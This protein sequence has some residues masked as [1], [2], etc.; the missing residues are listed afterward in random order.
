MLFSLRSTAPAVE[1]METAFR[2]TLERDADAPIDLLVEYLDLPDTAPTEYVERLT[3]L[4]K[5]KYS[6]TRIDVVVPDGL[7]ALRFV[8]E[9]RGVLFPAVPVV[10]MNVT[11]EE[12]QRVQPAPDVTGV[13][14]MPGGRRTMAVALDLLPDTQLVAIVGGATASDHRNA[15]IGR[16][17]VRERPTGITVLSLVELPL[18]EQLQRVSM[19]PQHSLVYFASFRADVAGRSMVARD[20]LRLVARSANAPTVG[21]SDSWL[22]YGI[23]GGDITRSDVP[24]ERAAGLTARLLKGE[25]VAALPPVAEQSSAVMFDWRELRRWRI[26]EKRLPKGSVVLFRA[27]DFWADH[28]WEVAGAVGLLL[29]QGLLIGALLVER[30]SRQRAQTGLVEA[31]RR[32]RTVADFTTDWEY[33]TRPD[34]SFAYISPSCLAISGYDAAAFTSRPALLT[35]I[36]VE[37]DRAAWAEHRRLHQPPDPPRR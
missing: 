25:P 8:L 18:E 16:R 23:L 36:I 30:R 19:L 3:D 1:T 20:V 34:G 35:D 24:P 31:E 2:R 14:L 9:R 29:G 17:Q 21:S 5:V 12:L 27:P 7:E 32:Y 28:K 13:L 4:L 22:G 33:W 37:E 10:F 11:R 6:E 26:D 15:E